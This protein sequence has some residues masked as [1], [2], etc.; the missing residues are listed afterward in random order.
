MNNRGIVMNNSNGKPKLEIQTLGG[1]SIR[2]D[3]EPIKDL[4][5]HKVEALLVYLV[6]EA[7]HP[8]RREALMTY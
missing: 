4:K 6:G 8:H 7:N 5:S 2:L 1:L 3:D